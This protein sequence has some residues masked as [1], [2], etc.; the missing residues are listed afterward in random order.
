ELSLDTQA[1]LLHALESGRV[2]P[3]GGTAEVEVSTRVIA[4][5]NRVLE[6]LLREHRFRPDLYYRLNVIRIEIPPLRERRDDILALV[7]HFLHRACAR[8]GRP[9]RGVSAGAPPPLLAPDWPRHA[10][11]L[12]NMS[13]RAGA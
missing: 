4:A 1:K 2:R 5:T 3:V 7:D 9:I 6:H 13:A 10:R 12:A 11:A 8:L